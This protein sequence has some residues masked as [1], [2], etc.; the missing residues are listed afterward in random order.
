MAIP[1]LSA[2]PVHKSDRGLVRLNRHNAQAVVSAAG[3]LLTLVP[4]ADLDGLLVQKMVPGGVEVMAGVHV[5]PQFG[6]LVAFGLGG[7]WVELFDEVALRLPNLDAAQ[8]L[9]MIEETRAARLLAG[10]RG[11]PPADVMA[12]ADLLVNL[13]RLAVE[14]AGKLVSLDLNPIMVL[15][16]GRG[17]VVVDARVAWR[18]A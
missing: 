4:V 12:L 11:Q 15:P 8:A 9:A 5:D 13:S 2:T 1:A 6:P 17:V 14:S 10:Y 7:V 3:D 16:Q 18:D